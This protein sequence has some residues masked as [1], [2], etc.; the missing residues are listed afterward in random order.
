[1]GWIQGIILGVVQGLTEFLPVSSSGHLVLFQNLLGFKEPELFFDICLHVGTLLAICLFFFRDLRDIGVT[2]VAIPQRLSQGESLR[3]QFKK[4]PALRLALFVL[5]GTIP[6]GIIGIYIRSISDV[7]FSSIRF[8]G[9]MLLVTGIILALTRRFQKGGRDFL[10]FNVL[11]AL[12]I[13]LAQGLAILPGISR[14]G[15]TISMGLFVGLDRDTA[16][17]YSFILSIPAIL[18]ALVM[19]WEVPIQGSMPGSVIAVGTLAATIIGYASLKLLMWLLKK[20]EFF[21][22]A[23]YC[24]VLGV[25][26]IGLSF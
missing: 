3:E 14:S 20:G 10:R 17:R 23:P 11:D 21:F 16:A 25:V 9:F 7:C 12:L 24:W 18:G 19:E 5:L 8:V 2:I 15:A 26:A 1:M 13:G 6:T 4:R 22:F